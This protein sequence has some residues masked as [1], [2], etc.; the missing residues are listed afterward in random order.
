MGIKNTNITTNTTQ[1]DIKCL[2]INLQRSRAASANL[3]KIVTEDEID[4][5]FIQE[6]YTI[7]AKVI[8]I[9]SKYTTFTAG[10]P[11]LGQP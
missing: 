1:T 6:P 3:T 4:I 9:P 7:Q 2:Q 10:G 5:I 8:G 11:G